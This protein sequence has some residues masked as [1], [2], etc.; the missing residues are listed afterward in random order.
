MNLRSRSARVFSLLILFLF[1]ALSR[2]QA[3]ATPP[4]FMN[5]IT[6]WY[7]PWPTV[8]FSGTR[9]WDTFTSWAEINTAPGLYNWTTLDTWLSDSQKHSVNLLY[10]FGMTPTWASSQPNDSSCLRFPG[11]CD[12]PNDLNL[13]GT[14]TDQV[15]KDFVT[16]IATHVGTRIQYW[17]VWNEAGVLPFWKGSY[18][19]LAR[20]AKDARFIILSINPNAKMLSSGNAALQSF[21]FKWWT[22]YG[23]AGGFQ[24]ADIIA[25]HGTVNYY[26]AAC[27]VYPQAE[28]FLSV[29]SNLRGVL[30]PYG[31]NSK[32]VWETEA[33]WGRTDTDCFTNQDLQAAFLA[34]YHL[35]HWSEGVARFYWRAWDDNVWGGLWTP[36]GGLNK[37]G[38]AYEQ[39]Y[40]WLVGS[41]MTKACSASGTVWTCD[42][43][44]ANGYAA[45]VVWDTSLSCSNGVCA[46]KEYTAAVQ[47]V[48]YRTIAGQ[49][50][51]ITGTQVPIGAK[52]ILLEN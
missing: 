45:Q 31:Q 25:I 47:Y 22:G 2:A 17:E 40:N 13:D 7:Y 32:P 15:W 4:T 29:M 27:G 28:N 52:P 14:G 19:Q 8:T 33:S 42:M 49:I 1:G 50:V 44:R 26:P 18:A 37:A 21:E 30:A 20:M 5:L 36:T 34:R 41:S 6:H 35:L 10:T 38:V 24:S 39:I 46:T 3:P 43:S 12:A 9:L 51:R 48:Q 11:A 16:A 23:N